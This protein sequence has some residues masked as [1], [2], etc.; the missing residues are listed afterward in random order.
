MRTTAAA[1]GALISQVPVG[2]MAAT[3]ISPKAKPGS[4][5]SELRHSAGKLMYLL[6]HELADGGAPSR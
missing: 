6:V 5:P 2:G 1:S 3:S 4:T